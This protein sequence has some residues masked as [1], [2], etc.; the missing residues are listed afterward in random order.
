MNSRNSFVFWLKL[1]VCLCFVFLRPSGSTGNPPPALAFA[2]P[3]SDS[4]DSTSSWTVTTAHGSSWELGTPTFGQTNSAHSAPSCWDVELTATYLDSTQTFLTSPLIDFNGEYNAR[5]T[6]WQNFNVEDYFDGTRLEY[7]LNNSGWTTLGL[8]GDPEGVN[9][10]TRNNIASSNQPAWSGTSAGW[11][12]SSYTLVPLNGVTGT[13]RFRFVFTSSDS[14]HVD[15]VSIDDFSIV[16]APAND[17]AISSVIHPMPFVINGSMDSVQVVVKNSGGFAVSSFDIG[18]SLDG[19]PAVTQTEN[20]SLNPAETDTFV[21]AVPYLVPDG[22]YSICVF[23]SLATDGNSLNDTVCTQARGIDL[24]TVPFQDS[25]DGATISW[26]DSSLAGSR[27]ELGLPSFGSTTS[28]H[29]GPS[30]WDINLAAAYGNNARSYLYSSFFDFTGLV[31][32]RLSFYQNRK[33]EARFDGLALDYS[34]DGGNSWQLLGSF[35]DENS[36]NWHSDTSI[37]ALGNQPG[38]DGDSQGWQKSTCVLSP[39]NT[40]SA[41]VQFRFR[42][43]SDGSSTND[44]VSIDDFQVLPAP[45]IDLSLNRLVAPLGMKRAGTQDSIIVHVRNLGTT[46]LDTLHFSFG[47]RGETMRAITWTGSLLPAATTDIFLDTLVYR[48]SDF[49]LLV[50]SSLSSD[51]DPTNDSLVSD[52]FG[53]P[54]FLPPFSDSLESIR[55][56]YST[57]ASSWEWGSP[58]SS[59]LDQS[60]DGV[61]CW[62]TKLSSDYP[63]R[64]NDYLYSPYFDFSNAY[65][66]VLKFHHWFSTEQGKDGGRIEYST[67][68]GSSWTRLGSVGDGASSNWYTTPSLSS[69]TQPAWSGNSAGWVLS[70]YKLNMLSGYSGGLVQFRMNF[71]SND[72][73]TANGWAIDD[74]RIESIP[75]YSTAAKSL[76]GITDPFLPA[77]THQTLGVYIQNTGEKELHSVFADLFCDGILVVS[78]SIH[79]AQHLE[80]GDSVL[81]TFSVP[82]IPSP[83]A[84]QV[85]A[86]TRDPDS[87]T[88]Q[89][90]GD[91]AVC[92]AAGMFDSVSVS[93]VL[94][95]SDDFEGSKPE[96]FSL[97]P[98]SGKFAA[99]VW[100]LGDPVKPVLNAAW[101]GTHAWATGLS[102]SYAALSAEALYTPVFILDSNTCYEAS[103]THR[104]RTE[105]FQDGGTVEF[106][107]DNGLTWQVLGTSNDLQWFNSSYIT[108]LKLPPAPGWSGTSSGWEQVRHQ[109]YFT[110]PVNL[111]LR[112][113]F[114][115]DASVQDEGWE[116]DQ[117][118]I[119]KVASCF[120]GIDEK[121]PARLQ[122][123]PNPVTEQLKIQMPENQGKQGFLS[124]ENT[125]GEEVLRKAMSGE[126]TQTL[127][128]SELPPGLYVLRVQDGQEMLTGRFIKK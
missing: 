92:D 100:Q 50:V 108:G 103:F 122:L 90:P 95:W 123:Y 91:D 112:F 68:G 113:R 75:A 25:F 36:Q 69:T 57:P 104:Y 128:V 23:T 28:T 49:Q 19:G 125:L 44:G 80:R 22:N 5:L 118:N 117:F 72:S 58:N 46:V 10:Y 24:F 62:K 88:D 59:V 121:V 124:I 32:A 9:W 12:C 74:W 101:N 18:Y 89:F 33:T 37:A 67:D 87:R 61:K 94:S 127:W 116:I 66:P 114:G 39:L 98:A 115:S 21:F 82:W 83:G 30:C 86:I 8:S 126:T 107:T 11:I 105:Q 48:P 96:W 120:I 1:G 73:V 17:L 45:A 56:F 99:S 93:T 27:W 85:C 31:N 97:D 3:Y 34:S 13:V 71:A 63:N 35:Q 42:F 7:N 41:P 20:V 29:S 81:H 70:T 52:L 6:F 119:Q 109:L 84:H 40:V 106:T 2:L 65:R 77:S 15:G 16:P 14:V 102:A 111:V 53:I 51:G 54:V 4:F 78:D 110:Q 64:A 26:F 79:F 38:W 55:N 76:Q 60:W 47:I 43:E